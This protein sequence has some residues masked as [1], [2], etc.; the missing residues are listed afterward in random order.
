MKKL[1]VL[2]ALL[3]AAALVGC[4]NTVKENSAL[5]QQTEIAQN[6]DQQTSSDNDTVSQTEK[7]PILEKEQVSDLL[8]SDIAKDEKKDAASDKQTKIAQNNGQQ[9]S[10]DKNS[11]SKT[12]KQTSRKDKETSAV[13]AQRITKDE[14]KAAALKHAGLTEKD[15]RF[16]E[17]ELD[18]DGCYEV[19]FDADGYEYDY[20]VDIKT[21]KILKFEKEPID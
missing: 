18:D 5:N 11:V 17:I 2:L 7:Q 8:E 3:L 4:G 20:D 16:L 21:G 13:L 9:S 19:S 15:I 12:E 1:T 10:S 14:A 6:N